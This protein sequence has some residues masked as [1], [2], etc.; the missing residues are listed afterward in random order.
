MASYGTQSRTRLSGC[1]SHIINVMEVV[2]VVYDNSVI[3]GH[4]GEQAQNRAFNAGFSSKEFPDS[5]H[6]LD[7]A[8]AVDIVPY[9]IDWEDIGRFIELSWVVKGVA[10]AQNVPLEWGGD[11]TSVRVDGGPDYAH[12]QLP[13]GYAT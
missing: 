10:A 9:P 13:R 4:R 11:W 1:H 5:R 7:P 2:V 6:N 12:W 8:L 3:W